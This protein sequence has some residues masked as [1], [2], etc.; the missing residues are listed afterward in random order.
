MPTAEVMSKYQSARGGWGMLEGRFRKAV[1]LGQRI[2]VEDSV[3][4][5]ELLDRTSIGQ[6]TLDRVRSQ[7]RG[8]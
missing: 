1:Q 2:A 6:G 3:R 5:K 8:G 4:F 7:A